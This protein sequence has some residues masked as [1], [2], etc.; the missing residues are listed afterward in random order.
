MARL[1]GALT[2]D[3]LSR[4]TGGVY[5]PPADVQPG[6]E[7]SR[8]PPPPPK[9]TTTIPTQSAAARR[10]AAASAAAAQREAEAKQKVVAQ[11]TFEEQIASF[12]AAT[13]SQIE[14]ATAPLLQTIA[15]LQKQ[16]Q[17][18]SVRAA[19]EM[20]RLEEEQRTAAINQ[21]RSQTAS[22]LQIQPA[23]TPAT[24]AASAAFKASAPV[25]LGIGDIIPSAVNI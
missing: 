24:A 11:P 22:N 3:Q 16:Q 7:S 6:W 17:E 4:Y 5:K 8:K 15:D 12:Q 2:Y 14:Q 18:T 21:Q 19:E 10:Y 23:A 1:T 25:I 20:R 13:Q 9:K